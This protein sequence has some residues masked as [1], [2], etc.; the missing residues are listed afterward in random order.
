MK[1]QWQKQKNDVQAI[2]SYENQT[3]KKKM[4]SLIWQWTKTQ[5]L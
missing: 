3:K 1:Y 5:Q 4:L 2:M